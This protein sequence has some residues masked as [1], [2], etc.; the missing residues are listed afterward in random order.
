MNASIMKIANTYMQMQIKM[1]LGLASSQGMAMVVES[2]THLN[3]F[4]DGTKN[5]SAEQEVIHHTT[6]TR[7]CLESNF[8]KLK[9]RRAPDGVNKNVR[10]PNQ[11]RAICQVVLQSY[12]EDKECEN[13]AR[14]EVLQK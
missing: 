11:K 14:G 2:V 6:S 5:V 8:A 13:K 1:L 12:G 3:Y 9:C 7:F 10:V 4:Q